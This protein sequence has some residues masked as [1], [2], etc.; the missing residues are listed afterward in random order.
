ME[1]VNFFKY[2][3]DRVPADYIIHC[4]VCAQ[5]R[6]HQVIINCVVYIVLDYNNTTTLTI[7]VDWCNYSNYLDG[8][9]HVQMVGFQ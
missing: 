8:G 9:N 3:V 6:G 4:T 7:D 5:A 1:N 2:D